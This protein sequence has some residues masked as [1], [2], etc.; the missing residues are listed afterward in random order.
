MIVRRLSGVNTTIIDSIQFDI[1]IPDN[2]LV[3]QS[4]T[5]TIDWQS[6]QELCYVGDT[7][8]I[9][10]W[11]H[12]TQVQALGGN[13][14]VEMNTGSDFF[15]NVSEENIFEG[16]DVYMN[17]FVPEVKMSELLLSLF[18]MFNLYVEVDTADENNLLIETRA[19]YYAN[20]PIIDWTYKLARDRSITIEPLG[21]LT[22]KEYIYTYSSDEDY[23][24]SRYQ[25]SKG[26]TYG[27]RR[28][29]IDNDFIDNK[30]EVQVVFSPSPLVNDGNSSRLITKV[31][32]ADIDEGRKPTDMNI[33]ILY[34]GGMIPSNPSWGYRS[35]AGTVT[36]Q[37]FSYPYAGHLDNPINP[38]V[39][40]NFGIPLELFYTANGYT[41]TVQ[42]TNANLFN[43]YHRDY[44]DEITDKDSKVMTAMFRLEPLDINRL[45]FRKQV[46]IDNGYWR[47]NKVMNYNPFKEGLTKVELIKIKDVVGIKQSKFILGTSGTI[48]SGKDIEKKPFGGI[49]T[50]LNGNIAPFNGVV[51]GIGNSISPSATAFKVIGNNNHISGGSYNVSIFGNNNSVIQGASNVAMFNTNGVTVSESDVT[52]VNG[53]KS[54]PISIVD[55]G[56]NGVSLPRCSKSLVRMVDGGG[57]GVVQEVNIHNLTNLIVNE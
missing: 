54:Y 23:Y 17:N 39:D 24:N 3:G 50:Q 25:E 47:L 38:S 1:D 49:K 48:G 27:R 43:L 36:V 53:I 9:E 8:W 46:L 51:N 52:Y 18:K 5:T 10:I 32:D 11:L 37:K 31:Y 35:N 42:Y 57:D 41:G 12:D 56:G 14:T 26:H 44:I 40:I 15:N 19:T 55:G 21:L 7:V 28:R 33:R 45:D 2:V 16:S 30:N 6:Q 20:A 34:Y 22:A 4:A 13:F 29:V